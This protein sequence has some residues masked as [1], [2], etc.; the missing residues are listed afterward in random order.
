MINKLIKYTKALSYTVVEILYE[1]NLEAAK[2][3]QTNKKCCE[4]HYLDHTLLKFKKSITEIIQ[5]YIGQ[6]NL[7][8][9]QY[10]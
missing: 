9:C 7:P 2:S 10:F 1:N 4:D 3:W 5:L 6:N 8:V